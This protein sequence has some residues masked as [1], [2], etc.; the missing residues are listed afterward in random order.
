MGTP[1]YMSPEQAKGK[2]EDIDTSADQWALA[3]IAWECLC[4]EGPFVGENV[5][6]ILFQIVHEPRLRFCPRSWA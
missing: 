1:N 4:G 5:P 2:T 3:C 6:S